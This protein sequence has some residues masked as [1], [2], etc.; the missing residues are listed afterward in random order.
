MYRLYGQTKI[1]STDN[2]IVVD[3]DDV[4]NKLGEELYATMDKATGV[5]GKKDEYD[6]TVRYPKFSADQLWKELLPREFWL[7]VNNFLPNTKAQLEGL[8][9]IFWPAKIVICTARGDL[10]TDEGL[11]K[12]FADLT[13]LVGDKYT[14]A[15]S[16]FHK[17]KLDEVKA[18]FPTNNIIAVVEDSPSTLKY[19]QMLRIPN[20]VKSPR[21]Y[22]SHVSTDL[23]WCHSSGVLAVGNSL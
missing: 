20:V 11:D 10:C 22:N 9:S 23:E 6:F 15:V 2:I 5:E 8:E 4:L 21:P 16:H 13:S 17:N 12:L 1:E 19:A 14:L 18:A 3:I 7:N